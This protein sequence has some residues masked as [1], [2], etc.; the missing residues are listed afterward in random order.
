MVGFTW[1]HACVGVMVINNYGQRI[2]NLEVTYI[3]M[4]QDPMKNLLNP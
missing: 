3:A 4:K 2:D 1:T